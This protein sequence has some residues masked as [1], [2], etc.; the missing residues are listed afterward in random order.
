MKPVSIRAAWNSGLC[1]HFFVGS[2][3]TNMFLEGG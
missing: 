3:L 1:E 2:A